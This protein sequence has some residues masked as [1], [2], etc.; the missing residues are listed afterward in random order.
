MR[1]RQ[2]NTGEVL[3]KVRNLIKEFKS[4]GSK[5]A[6][7]AINDVSFDLYRGETFGLI[8]ESGSGKTTVGRC[9]LRLIEQ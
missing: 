5:A 4:P 1:G 7:H 8:G 3:L 2:E 9:I 6:V